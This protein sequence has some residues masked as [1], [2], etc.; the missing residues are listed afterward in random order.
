MLILQM[1]MDFTND[2]MALIINNA[3]VLLICVCVCV[4]VCVLC[5]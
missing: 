1:W 4:C 2:A 5:L 3:A